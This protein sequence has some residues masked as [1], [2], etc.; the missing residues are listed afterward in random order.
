MDRG[1]GG[2]SGWADEAG[3]EL[4]ST[5]FWTVFLCVRAYV[6]FLVVWGLG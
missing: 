2:M 1:S 6:C 4:V 3:A 5:F